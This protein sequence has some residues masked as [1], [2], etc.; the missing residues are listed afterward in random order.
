M[1]R[2]SPASA[3]VSPDSASVSGVRAP[4]ADSRWTGA[5]MD[6]LLCNGK[7]GKRWRLVIGG[8]CA[9]HFEL[10]HQVMARQRLGA[11]GIAGLQGL[12]LIHI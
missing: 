1:I 7:I 4:R 10:A 2:L 12:S 9:Q 5:F 6:G 3:A 8:Q 11:F